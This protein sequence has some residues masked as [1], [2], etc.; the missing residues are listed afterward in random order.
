MSKTS[1]EK[2]VS[3]KVVI[4]IDMDSGTD[5]ESDLSLKITF[6]LEQSE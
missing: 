3:N 5:A 6:I 2:L 4:D 1:T